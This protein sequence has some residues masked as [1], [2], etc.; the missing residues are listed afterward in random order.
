[1]A[2]KRPRIKTAVMTLRV[3]PQ[4]KAAA[5]LAAERDHR[6]LTSFIE[7]LILKYCKDLDLQ[8]PTTPNSEDTAR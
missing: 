2:R 7:V 8:F 6:S 4:V 5:E 1:M 3:D